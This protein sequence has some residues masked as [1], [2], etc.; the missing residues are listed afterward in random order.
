MILLS[1][2]WLLSCDQVLHI[3][4]GHFYVLQVVLGALTPLHIGCHSTGCS[5]PLLLP[6]MLALGWENSQHARKNDGEASGGGRADKRH[7]VAEPEAFSLLTAC[8]S[9]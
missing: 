2:L 8:S 3:G 7:S 5:V 1:F 4:L 6:S 9:L